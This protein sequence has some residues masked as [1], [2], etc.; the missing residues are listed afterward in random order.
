GIPLLARI[1]AVADVFDALTTDR[2]Y[3][4]ALSVARALAL[5]RE[6]AGRG[7]DPNVV[8]TLCRM[9]G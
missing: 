7:F 3:R 5:L 1:I 6:E 2:P 4:R 9:L 8:E